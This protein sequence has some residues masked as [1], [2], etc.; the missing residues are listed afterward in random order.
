[1]VHE[2]GCWL[3]MQN[4]RASLPRLKR[5]IRSGRRSVLSQFIF[6][7]GS[8][9]EKR[10]PVGPESSVTWKDNRLKAAKR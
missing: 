10:M 1:M 4:G 8:G 7:S 9:L 5:L 6:L 2:A 3:K